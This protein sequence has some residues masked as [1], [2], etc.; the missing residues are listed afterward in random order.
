MRLCDRHDEHMET[1]R[2]TWDGVGGW[3]CLG[4]PLLSQS[5]AC[6]VVPTNAKQRAAEKKVYLIDQNLPRVPGPAP[7][8]FPAVPGRVLQTLWAIL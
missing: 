1:E 3:R 2:P 6:L 8:A 5:R 7:P 4:V